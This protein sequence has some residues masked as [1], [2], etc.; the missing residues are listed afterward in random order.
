M[1]DGKMRGKSEK[2][3]LLRR[4]ESLSLEGGKQ[5]NEDIKLYEI[6]A[7]TSIKA[8]N[9]LVKTYGE[10]YVD[11]NYDRLE[12]EVKQGVFEAILEYRKGGNR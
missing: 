1:A 11:E 12:K 10:K 5:M 4:G 6:I 7:Q 8:W 3:R 2:G 9:K